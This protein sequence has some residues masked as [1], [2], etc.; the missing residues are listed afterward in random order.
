M[1][2][3]GSS[4]G[5]IFRSFLHADSKPSSKEGIFVFSVEYASTG[6][7]AKVIAKGQVCE[8]SICG[9]FGPLE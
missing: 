3:I 6:R 8:V 4:A 1:L 7:F 9:G 2:R 5:S